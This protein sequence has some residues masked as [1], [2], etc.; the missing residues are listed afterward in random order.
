MVYL[1]FIFLFH[2][3]KK[4]F[5]L[6][7][8]FRGTT[9]INPFPLNRMF[10]YLKPIYTTPLLKER[11]LCSFE[12]SPIHMYMY[13]Y[14]RC[15]FSVLMS[16]GRRS[17]DLLGINLSLCAL[18]PDSTRMNSFP[19]MPCP[20]LDRYEQRPSYPQDLMSSSWRIII[21][22]NG[23]IFLLSCGNG[24]LEIHNYLP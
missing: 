16:F 18:S 13:L 23:W 15:R 14:R 20:N 5:F 2:V 17:L 12:N 9:I 10:L 21:I 4:T 7:F 3:E 22:V 19:L 24:G 8:S 6:F 1:G 11:F